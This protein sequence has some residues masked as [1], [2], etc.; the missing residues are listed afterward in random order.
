MEPSWRAG[1]GVPHDG[2]EHDVPEREEG[3]M[4]NVL[5]VLV[6]LFVAFVLGV[7]LFNFVIMPRFVQTNV[8]VVVPRLIGLEVEQAERLC[9]RRGLKLQIDDR[10]FSEGVPVDRVLSQAPTSD[11]RVKRGRT[12]RVHISLGTQM[13]SVPDIRG[14]TLRQARLQLDN[15]NLVLGRVSRIYVG[16]TGQEVRATRPRSG[17]ETAVG[18]AIDVLV[19]V[20]EGAEP[21]LMP[22]FVG[23]ALDEV[24]AV[25]VDRGFRVGRLTYRSRKGVYPGTILETYPAT[26]SLILE[27]ESID[28]VA[29]TPD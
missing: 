6:G 9:H 8:E 7:A 29:A 10:R 17:S 5:W 16:E 23:R 4:R 2:D 1:D 27:G 14:M 18:N 22:D 19:A 28:L 3:L 26:G 21:Y 24:R 12:I 11:S 15:A 13:V 25:I 20:G